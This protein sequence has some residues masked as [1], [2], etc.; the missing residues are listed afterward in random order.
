[1]RQWFP[2]VI[3]RESY[4][5]KLG[6]VVYLLGVI[7]F[8]GVG[9]LLEIFPRNETDDYSNTIEWNLTLVS[10][11]WLLTFV[12]DFGGLYVSLRGEYSL[13]KINAS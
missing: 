10:I 7:I 12:Y 1:M 13:L 6:L 4:Y 11:V 9:V 3:I 2:Y 5:V 8:C